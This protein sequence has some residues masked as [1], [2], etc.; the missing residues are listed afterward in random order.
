MADALLVNAVGVFFSTLCHLDIQTQTLTSLDLGDNE[1]GA[2][3][4]YYLANALRMNT[5]KGL[6]HYLRLHS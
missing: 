4:A 3:G 6:L 2:V 1:I 5:V